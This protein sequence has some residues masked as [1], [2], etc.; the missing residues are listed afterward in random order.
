MKRLLIRSFTL[1]LCCF[2]AMSAASVQASLVNGGFD[3]ANGSL[4]GPSYVTSISGLASVGF[5]SASGWSLYN[6]ANTTTTTELLAT[7]DPSGSGSMIH[8][9]S[10]GPY[11][12]LFQVFSPVGP[13]S[14][15]VDVYVVSGTVFF[16]L[17]SNSGITLLGSVQSTTTG[18][19]ET[20]TL[21]T[22]IGNP[23][24]IVLYTS[25]ANGGEFYFDRASL[26]ALS[27]VVV[28]E[29]TTVFAGVLLLLPFAFSTIRHF[30]SRKLAN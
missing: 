6:N 21:P 13:T 17:Y 16:G 1:S 28:P 8:L 15:S 7:T 18:Q 24:E 12:G 25:D 2:L 3:T 20:L 22:T 30:R 19:W 14:A 10:G 23:D 27:P 9:T 11:C 4:S 5:S 29:P 26:P